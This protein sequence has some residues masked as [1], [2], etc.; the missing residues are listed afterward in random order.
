MTEQPDEPTARRVDRC[1]LIGDTTTTV[2]VPE[3]WLAV[4]VAPAAA[5]VPLSPVV[6]RGLRGTQDPDG[7]DGL[8]GLIL[9]GA[10][11]PAAVEL[12]G[13]VG[14]PVLA[15][16]GPVLLAPGGLLFASAGWWR[17]TPG[18]RR[19]AAGPRWPA[20]AWQSSVP[21]LAVRAV[22]AGW[23]LGDGDSGP[24]DAVAVDPDRPRLLFDATVTGA[25][26]AAALRALPP[27]ARLITD[28]VPL[29]PGQ[30]AGRP[31]AFA[32]ARELGEPVQLFNGVPLHAP[33]GDVVVY[34]LDPAGLPVWPEPAWLLCC[35]PDGRE[36]V[37]ASSPPQPA[38]RPIDAATYGMDLGWLV[39]LSGGGLIAEPSGPLL[40]GRGRAEV[41]PPQASTPADEDAG[42]AT[43]DLT[44]DL[45][46][47]AAAAGPATPSTAGGAVPDP[48][49]PGGVSGPL[50]EADPADGRYRVVVG[51]AGL[52]INDLLWPPVSALFTAVLTDI[53]AV[54]D[55]RVAG[56]ATAWGL[57]AARE[58]AERHPGDAGS[59]AGRV[60]A[61]R[62]AELLPTA[63]ADGAD[64]VPAADG[65]RR[66]MLALAAAAIVVLVLVGV[67]FAWP[68]GGGGPVAAEQEQLEPGFVPGTGGGPS[69]PGAS[70]RGSRAPASAS[71]TPSAGRPSGSAP[72]TG[73]SAGPP[74]PSGAQ[75]PTQFSLGDLIDLAMAHPTRDSG[76]ADVYGSGNIVDGNPMSYWES[77]TTFPQWVQVDLGA[78]T[79]VRRAVLRLP[80]LAAW[81]ARTQRIE[82]QASTDDRTFRS[83]VPATT[84]SFSNDSGQRVSVALP[85]GAVRYVRVVFTAN[86]VQ[87]A[88][89]LSSLEVYGA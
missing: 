21:E 79:E 36:Q 22:P 48:D 73:G 31:V 1:L 7:P 82:I 63:A 51:T 17:H 44:L 52:E 29:L 18:G 26:L 65:R 14:R 80:P 2:P 64:A 83:I 6:L 27:A 78:A 24:A 60:K 89:Q 86:S 88:G 43:I 81:P 57:A 46:P 19:V 70:A 15:T 39:R 28:V 69:A 34:A 42:P 3:G 59:A 35:H 10:G 85:A 58:L 71:G 53:P 67:A 23:L 74:A 5:P 62:A 45:T 13:A 56:D 30:G 38:L 54:V 84:Y 87:G 8:E 12:S 33:A 47:A 76:H 61:Y 55:M 50:G 4:V 49:A 40:P 25:S 66:R 41:P 77:H 75:S 32:A 68:R 16:D 37:L 9:L 20:P 11:D 72:A